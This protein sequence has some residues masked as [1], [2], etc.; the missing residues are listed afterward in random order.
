VK[1]HLCSEKS[2]SVDSLVH[3]TIKAKVKPLETAPLKGLL[4]CYFIEVSLSIVTALEPSEV[5]DLSTV[6]VLS[7]PLLE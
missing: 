4:F 3:L 6:P 2:V 7:T 5:F 1:K